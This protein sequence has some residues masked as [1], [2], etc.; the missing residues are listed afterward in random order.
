[1]W[2][3]EAVHF[4]RSSDNYPM[5][6]IP[7]YQIQ[8]VN[9]ISAVHGDDNSDQETYGSLL[10][11]LRTS[12]TEKSA[13]MEK[14]ESRADLS[15]YNRLIQIQTVPDGFSFGRTYYVYSPSEQSRKSI[16]EDLSK[17]A[18]LASS[19]RIVVSKF[20]ASQAAVR[21][22]YESNA[23]QLFVGV[24]ILTVSRA[25]KLRRRQQYFP[26]PPPNIPQPNV[27]RG[28]AELQAGLAVAERRASAEL[29]R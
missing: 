11:K 6:M 20:M 18:K 28:W 10:Q 9:A 1:M 8:S 17:L 2:T 22:F 4:Y 24:L 12:S 5:D 7:L 26:I 25:S 16:V 14:V 15:H 3:N 23:F 27:H 19:R 21:S 13:P 29:V